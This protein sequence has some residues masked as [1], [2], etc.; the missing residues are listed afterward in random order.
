MFDVSLL[1]SFQAI[2]YDV[3]RKEALGGLFNIILHKD[4]ELVP[5]LLL[6]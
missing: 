3:I 5:T 6:R 4:I 1:N 2:N